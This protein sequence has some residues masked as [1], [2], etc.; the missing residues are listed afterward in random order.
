LPALQWHIRAH[1]PPPQHLILDG[2]G[3]LLDDAGRTDKTIGRSA[4]ERRSGACKKRRAGKGRDDTDEQLDL[5]KDLV[6]VLA[7]LAI[8]NARDLREITGALFHC[9]LL[10]ND[11]VIAV[12][13]QK[14]GKEYHDKVKDNK[15][16]HVEGP[17]FLHMW[18]T[19]IKVLAAATA[20]KLQKEIK[21][22]MVGYWNEMV[23]KKREDL[24]M[25]VRH[26]RIRA[27][28]G[29]K[30]MKLSFAV[31][32]HNVT[33]KFEQSLRMVL[34]AYDGIKKIGPPPAG[35]LEREAVKL[36]EKLK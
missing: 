13:M 30:E 5:L 26:C 33:T 31:S 19:V 32:T 8:A 36:L 20:G 34:T 28:H 22:E 14:T 1:L 27:T 25:E 17:P 12:E 4:R 15:K 16:S 3:G 21:D 24:E 9:F 10:P 18:I 2:S 23:K 6:K 7:G 29:K 35:H 11:S